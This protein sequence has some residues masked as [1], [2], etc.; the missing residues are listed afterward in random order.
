MKDA[1]RTLW[2]NAYKCLLRQREVAMLVLSCIN[3]F[4][5]QILFSETSDNEIGFLY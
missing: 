3:F 4:F 5:K 1:V 2:Y